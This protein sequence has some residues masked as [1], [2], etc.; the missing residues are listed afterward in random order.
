M[1]KK[2][3]LIVAC[4]VVLILVSCC[5]IFAV[6]FA[7]QKDFNFENWLDQ[8]TLNNDQN[9]FENDQDNDLDT[10][11]TT[12]STTT[13]TTNNNLIPQK[14]AIIVSGESND[15]Q[16]YTWFK[17]STKQAYDLLI[18]KGYSDNN[19]DYLFETASETGVD[20][21]STVDNFTMVIDQLREKSTSIDNIVVILIGHGYFD[22][23]NSYYTL[24]D[25]N[26]Q[27]TEMADMF[28][29]IKRDK[30][31]FVFSPCNTGGFIDDLSGPDTVVISSTRP[32]E[33]NKAAFIE[34]FLASFDGSGDK[35]NDG[36]VS[37]AEAFN[38]ASKSVGDQYKNNNWGNLTE[39][40]QLDDNG[41]GISHEAPVPNEGDGG[42]ARESYL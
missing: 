37:F 27:D 16:H 14:Y 6:F 36:N 13:S 1:G 21:E 38:F 31:V 24:H 33:S 5:C 12:I 41:D 25:Y 7:V 23:T 10:T 3:I 26:I 22:G 4:L 30:V 20:Y 39:H 15:A 18:T 11:T 35:N 2:T 29:D 34:P 42:L 32:D 40:A 28:S 19:I 17:N 8:N 9:D